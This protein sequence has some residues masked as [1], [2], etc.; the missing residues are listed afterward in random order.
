MSKAVVPDSLL[1]KTTE[2][3]FRAF[4]STFTLTP[5]PRKETKEKRKFSMYDD[6]PHL[7][8]DLLAA[9]RINAAAP[10]PHSASATSPTSSSFPLTFDALRPLVDHVGSVT[11]LDDFRAILTRRDDVELYRRAWDELKV[12]IERW[13]DES[14]GDAGYGVAME[15]VKGL[16]GAAVAEGE[17]EVF[18]QWM[19]RVKEGWRTRRAGW[20]A[21]LK[22]EG[23]RVIDSSEVDDSRFTPAQADRWFE[24]VD[25]SSRVR[26]ESLPVSVED[27]AD[28]F[29]S[30]D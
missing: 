12:I 9:K 19:E 21:K 13:V 17:A 22:A 27:D 7:D 3:A 29:D 10:P 4:R 26:S 23:V 25:D 18:N 20:W 14:Y 11:P 1:L 30:M 24:D 15:C 28:L 2:P 5:Q 6:Q 16:R 8:A